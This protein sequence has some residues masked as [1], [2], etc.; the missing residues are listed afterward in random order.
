MYTINQQYVCTQETRLLREIVF[1]LI[2]QYVYMQQVSNVNISE[3]CL[4]Y[5]NCIRDKRQTDVSLQ[6]ERV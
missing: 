3:I 1:K 2:R 5:F 4:Y 6:H